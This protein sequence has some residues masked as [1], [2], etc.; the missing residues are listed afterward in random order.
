M[1]GS[2]RL[3]ELVRIERQAERSPTRTENGWQRLQSS[4][5][6][7]GPLAHTQLAS[8]RVLRSLGTGR[9]TPVLTL[10]ALGLISAAGWLANDY[11][12]T[13]SDVRSL[14]TPSAV[15]NVASASVD[16]PAAAVPLGSA[17]SRNLASS[18]PVTPQ[19]DDNERFAHPTPDADRK[20]ANAA[21][22]SG[23]NTFEQELRLIKMARQQLDS[24]LAKQA[25]A[26]LNQHAR[27]FPSGVFAGEREAL[28]LLA[29]CPTAASA[30]RSTLVTS[31]IRA[32]PGSPYS[33]RVKRACQGNNEA[34]S[35]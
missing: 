5:A 6:T 4:L 28:R 17:V 26:L 33:D 9:W 32:Y 7:P 13:S 10:G 15:A 14:V 29:T 1:N 16:A 19:L 25:V 22:T 21:A 31:F 24:G 3:A 34:G 30:Q 12:S 8:G 11:R 23:M 18:E 27:L 20:V 35:R 2:N